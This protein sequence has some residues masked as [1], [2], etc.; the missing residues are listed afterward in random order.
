VLF[1]SIR[2]VCKALT[3]TSYSTSYRHF[4]DKTRTE[5]ETAVDAVFRDVSYQG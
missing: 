1:R 3:H 4:T 2:N 5:Q